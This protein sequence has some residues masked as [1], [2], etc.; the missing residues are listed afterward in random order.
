MKTNPTI[1][2]LS[3]FLLSL[4][5]LFATASKSFIQ[6]GN[7]KKEQI[8]AMK[9][10]F[11]TRKLEL[12]PAEAQVFWPVYNQFE[13]EQEAL[14][15]RH[16][17]EKMV[18]SEDDYSGLSDADT[19]KMVDNEIIFRQQELDILKKYHSQFKKVLPIKKVALL[20]KAQQ[21]FQKE[22]LKKI[23]ERAGKN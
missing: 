20:Y 16:R 15:K 12:T 23:Q 7:T 9:V 10:A 5:T 17:Q 1:T 11:I 14:R 21:D 19:E 22:L 4:S 6:N 3:A 13:A 8:E 2:L 18:N